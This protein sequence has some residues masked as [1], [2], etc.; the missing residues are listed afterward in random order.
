MQWRQHCCA[1]IHTDFWEAY[2]LVLSPKRYKA[3]GKEKGKTCYIER[4]NNTFR[5]RISRIIRKTLSFSKKK[6]NTIRHP[7]GISFIT[8]TLPSGFDHHDFH[9]AA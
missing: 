1:F 7:F 2:A 6:L 5:Q 9:R 4:L 3:V 8:I